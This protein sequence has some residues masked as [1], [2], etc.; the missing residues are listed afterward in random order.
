[1]KTRDGE[2][3]MQMNSLDKIDIE[4]RIKSADIIT[5]GKI[6]CPKC[7][8]YNNFIGDKDSY[9]KHPVQIFFEFMGMAWIAFVSFIGGMILFIFIIMFIQYIIESPMSFKEVTNLIDSSFLGYIGYI[10]A[11][12]VMYVVTKASYKEKNLHYG[13]FKISTEGIEPLTYDKVKF[14]SQMELI[15]L[16]CP[17]CGYEMNNV[18][19]KSINH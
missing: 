4:T 15:S 1:M 3:A 11:L 5:N 8:D 10:V 19:I 13:K 6:I 7:G 14:P 9:L 2:E 12:P 16:I 17:A 18:K